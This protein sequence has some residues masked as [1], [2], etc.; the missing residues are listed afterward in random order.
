MILGGSSKN[1]I[2]LPLGAASLL[3]ATQHT[4]LKKSIFFLFLGNL[5]CLV[6]IGFYNGLWR[7]RQCVGVVTRSRAYIMYKYDMTWYMICHIFQRSSTKPLV[8]KPTCGFGQQNFWNQWLWS[9]STA[10]RLRWRDY[11]LKMLAIICETFEDIEGVWKIYTSTLQFHLCSSAE[12][13]C[14]CNC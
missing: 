14:H 5:A 13:V 11:G 2:P 12:K 4:C 9:K 8:R 3:L 10:S 6:R 1:A 7:G